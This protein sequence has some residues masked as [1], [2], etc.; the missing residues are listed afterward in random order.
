MKLVPLHRSFY[1][2]LAH[3]SCRVR[4]AF[5]SVTTSFAMDN[6]LLPDDGSMPTLQA[7]SNAV[8]GT[9][10]AAIDDKIRESL[11]SVIGRALPN[12]NASDSDAATTANGIIR[13]LVGDLRTRH[14]TVGEEVRRAMLSDNDPA[15]QYFY[16]GSLIS[17]PEWCDKVV[18]FLLEEENGK[19]LITHYLQNSTNRPLLAGFLLTKHRNAVLRELKDE[20]LPSA[21]LNLM[22]LLPLTW[23][24]EE[25]NHSDQVIAIREALY[26]IVKNKQRRKVLA[27]DDSVKLKMLPVAASG[28]SYAKL[29]F[30]EL[31]EDEN[32]QKDTLSFL[33]GHE[34][35]GGKVLSYLVRECFEKL[36][37][38]KML[39][40]FLLQGGKCDS[41]LRVINEGQPDKG[42]VATVLAKL[43]KAAPREERVALAEKMIPFGVIAHFEDLKDISVFAGVDSPTVLDALVEAGVPARVAESPA[44]NL[45]P[46]NLLLRKDDSRVAAALV[47][48]GVPE[49]LFLINY[50]PSEGIDDLGSNFCR[51]RDCLILAANASDRDLCDAT[52]RAIGKKLRD[53]ASDSVMVKRAC[54]VVEHLFK[55]GTPGPH[56]EEALA[57]HNIPRAL[58]E[59]NALTKADSPYGSNY[60]LHDPLVYLARS[61]NPQLRD[62]THGALADALGSDGDGNAVALSV[63]ERPRTLWEDSS[64][65]PAGPAKAVAAP[66]RAETAGFKDAV[67]AKTL[68]AHPHFARRSGAQT[69]IENSPEAQ[70]IISA[71]QTS[72]KPAATLLTLCLAA[73]LFRKGWFDRKV[74]QAADDELMAAEVLETLTKEGA[75][76]EEISG[77]TTNHNAM[78]KRVE[79]V[80]WWQK[81]IGLLQRV[82]GYG[83]AAMGAYARYRR[84]PLLRHTGGWL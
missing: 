62:A 41:V 73:T 78:K 65:V 69:L 63:L 51:A 7:V 22:G 79:R 81:K 15:Q 64:G 52:I 27:A 37:N 54:S 4:G 36:Q 84:Q 1:E 12:L 67:L 70:S 13:T 10:R 28:K 57:A 16:F 66:T 34:D 82:T 23:Q 76:A 20:D 45:L 3:S 47:A 19:H 59:Q 32:T 14:L 48:S 72:Y 21:Y 49:A 55:E 33:L 29:F 50:P 46:L 2:F 58:L 18:S 74:R 6:P 44:E 24:P 68:T 5:F 26:D 30:E 35:H 43:L 61:T 77:A 9:T 8:K 40:H 38:G 75:P 39:L 56:T 31:L 80:Q 60:N 17:S 71:S 83:G 11:G 42:Y 53:E 25:G